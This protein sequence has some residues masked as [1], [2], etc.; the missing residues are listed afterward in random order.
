MLVG[1]RSGMCLGV[2]PVDGGA[3]SNIRR[4]RRMEEV[5]GRES[6]KDAG[7]GGSLG[8]GQRVGNGQGRDCCLRL[9][10]L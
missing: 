5:A 2:S 8:G 1:A 10:L 4:K 6:R 7:L 3:S 9:H